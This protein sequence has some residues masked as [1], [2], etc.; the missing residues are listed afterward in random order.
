MSIESIPIT[1]SSAYA[2]AQEANRVKFYEFMSDTNY[3]YDFITYSENEFGVDIDQDGIVDI[4][5]TQKD[6]LVTAIMDNY[7]CTSK[8][9]K[10]ENNGKINFSIENVEDDQI[11]RLDRP[12]IWYTHKS[13]FQCV[14]DMTMEPHLGTVV[15]V[16][17]HW[18][19]CIIVSVAAAASV[20]CLDSRM[21]WDTTNHNPR[22][23]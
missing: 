22:G 1:R 18:C 12:N 4:Q 16:I 8:I 19:P 14:T 17:S 7:I 9:I 21:R 13:W 5:M 15:G 11:T 20:I 10:T 2:N 23:N 6:G 3:S